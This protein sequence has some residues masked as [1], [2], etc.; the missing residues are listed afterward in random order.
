L[1]EHKSGVNV[2]EGGYKPL[3]VF[4]KSTKDAFVRQECS[5]GSRGSWC[6][7][8]I[9]LPVEKALGREGFGR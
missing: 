3:S 7:I 5:G 4:Y 9:G 1:V 8:Y 2:T 6:H